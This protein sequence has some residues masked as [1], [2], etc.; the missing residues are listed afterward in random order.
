[1]KSKIDACNSSLGSEANVEHRTIIR[2]R[3]DRAV[4][5]SRDGPERGVIKNRRPKR[6]EAALLR[7]Q[8]QKLYRPTRV[9]ILFVGE[10]PPASGR[11]FY[12]ADSG[13]YRA[14]RDAF[15]TAFPGLA[16]DNFLN[17]FRSLGC[18]LVDLCAE[19]VDRLE[20]KPRRDA[21]VKG[22]TRLSRMLRRLRPRVVIA[23]VQSI[24]S[25]VRRSE[26][27]A[28]WSGLHV[29]L[30]YPGRWHHH[31]NAFV[32]ALVSLFREMKCRTN[33]GH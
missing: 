17:S 7:E 33:R 30:P 9:R 1:M 20:R 3:T 18:Y 10:A 27:R 13:L 25:N 26:R 12:N 19:P 24:G 2:G 21:C 15:I 4:T 32:R 14:V 31:R 8:L 22:E 16:G 11:F 5:F 29:E 28:K 6:R 23:V